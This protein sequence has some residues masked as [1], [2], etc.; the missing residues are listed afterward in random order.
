MRNDNMCEWPNYGG[1][2]GEA[3][4]S[5]E[6][7]NVRLWS[8]PDNAYSFPIGEAIDEVYRKAHTHTHT[9]ADIILSLAAGA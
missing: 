3:D 4:T 6:Y 1:H 9:L 7:N 8:T 5:Y 2:N